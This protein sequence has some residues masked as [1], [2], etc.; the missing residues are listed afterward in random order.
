MLTCHHIVTSCAA[1]AIPIS[2]WG[3]SEAN[4]LAGETFT[5]Q[6]TWAMQF[7]DTEKI[8][9]VAARS[10]EETVFSP[11][12]ITGHHEVLTKYLNPNLVAISTVSEHLPFFKVTQPLPCTAALHCCPALHCKPGAES[13]AA[14]Y[15]IILQGTKAA[16]TGASTN[17]SVHMYCIDTITGHVMYHVAHPAS[18]GPTHLALSDNWVVQTYWSD[19]YHNDLSTCT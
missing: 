8:D 1:C 5:S 3:R 15:C 18:T 4:A 12:Y 13:S 9:T 19:R 17:P 6:E 11:T 10:L 14:S 7:P 16:S 2:F